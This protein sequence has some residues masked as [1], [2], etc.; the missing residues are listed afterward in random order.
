MLYAVAANATHGLK[1]SNADKRRAVAILLQDPL[2]SIDPQTG[3]PWSD[4]GIARQCCVDHKTVARL[5][6]ELAPHTGD[7]PSMN[8]VTTGERAFIH[9]KTGQP[10]TMD[11]ARIGRDVPVVANLTPAQPEAV[12]DTLSPI[13]EDP[14]SNIIP[15]GRERLPPMEGLKREAMAEE[16]AQ[17]VRKE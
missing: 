5:R 7:F 3:A 11:T 14:P 1:R 9:P 15:F 17:P 8:N 4:R 10:T 13:R 12:D 16:A 2:V 6:S